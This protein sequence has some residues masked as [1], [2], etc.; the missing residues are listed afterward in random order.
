MNVSYFITS[1]GAKSYTKTSPPN[2]IGAMVLK[3]KLGS[4]SNQNYIA[5]MQC[6]PERNE[7]G[8]ELSMNILQM[9]DLI[10]SYQGVLLVMRKVGM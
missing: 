1:K 6:F 5:C 10:H 4:P 3:V 8:K 9:V 7:G 2:G